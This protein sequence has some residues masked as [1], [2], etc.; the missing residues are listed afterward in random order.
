MSSAM[1]LAYNLY[2]I[3]HNLPSTQTTECL[4]QRLIKRLKQPDNFWGALYETYAFALFAI[5]GFTMELEDETDGTVTHCEF[6]ARGKSGRTYSTECKSRNRETMPV[7]ADGSLRIEAKTLGLAKKL[8]DA[9]SKKANH[10]RVV[11]LDLDLP[12][13]TGIEQVKAVADA[14]VQEIHGLEASLQINNQPAP[15]A[16]VFVTNTPDHRNES[17]DSYGLQAFATGF[18]ISDFGHG[19]MYRGMHDLMRS[20]ERHA[21]ILSLKDAAK[22]RHTIPSTFDGSNPAL[23]FSD[24]PMPRLRVGDWYAVPDATGAQIEAQLCQGTVIETKKV[25]FCIYRTK[26]GL[27][28][29]CQNDLTDDELQA[30]RLYPGTFFGVVDEN[31]GRKKVESAVDW[32]DFFFESFQ[33]TPKEKLLEFMSGAPDFDEL[34]KQN[35]RDLAIT[36]CERMA[37]H[38]HHQNATTKAAA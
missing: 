3:H 13:L 7:N 30:Y 25:A 19:V 24:N 38:V 12:M 33:H 14:G 5:A 21:D 4:C 9:L 20:R 37:L 22:I 8:K 34:S 2:L 26:A 11:F 1:S 15:P 32:F 18:K 23:T 36:Y 35:Q 16:Y 31:A 27:H 6:S 10:E 28:I 17:D 29:M